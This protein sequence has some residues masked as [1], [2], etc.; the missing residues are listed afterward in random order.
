M[1]K[2]TLKKMK[3]II[4]D[5]AKATKKATRSAVKTVK[6]GQNSRGQE[7]GG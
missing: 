2:S 5:A 7:S 1:A 4:G 3:D 6:G